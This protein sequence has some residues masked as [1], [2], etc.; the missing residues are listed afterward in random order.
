[1]QTR[2][3]ALLCLGLA[4]THALRSLAQ[5]P[6]RMGAAARPASFAASRRRGLRPPLSR[7][8]RVRMAIDVD[9]RGAVGVD[10]RGE[11]DRGL[12][13]EEFAPCAERGG[14]SSAAICALAAVGGGSTAV[15]VAEFKRAV[16]LCS[17]LLTD[18]LPDDR[19][20]W[21]LPLLGG[22]AVAFLRLGTPPATTFDSSLGR[23][24]EA[25]MAGEPVDLGIASVRTV[26][27]VFTLG[28]GCSLG[29]EGP[30][31]ELGAVVARLSVAIA[32]LSGLGNI[33]SAQRRTLV[34]SGAA[35][36]VAAG[37][38][39]P[40]A[41]IAFAYEVASALRPFSPA[42]SVDRGRGKYPAILPVTLASATAALVARAILA[43]GLSFDPS[44]L[45]EGSASVAELPIYM[46]LGCFCGGGAVVFRYATANSRA[47]FRDTLSPIVSPALQPIVGGGA[48]ALLSLIVPEVQFS[49]YETLDGL[50]S[51]WSLLSSPADPLVLYAAKS[52]ATAVCLGSGLVGG[53]FAP[54]LFLGAALGA[55]FSQTFDGLSSVLGL[56]HATP[57]ELI[58]TGAASLLSAVFSSPFTGALLI[59]DKT[60]SLQLLL[61][62]LL[63]AAI[64]SALA[65]ELAPVDTPRPAQSME[66]VDGES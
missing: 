54:S 23:N 30:A 14:A 13:D 42:T 51:S 36:G 48:C 5:P 66:T 32:G 29:P 16:L 12:F 60:H 63:S 64:A 26:A 62:S 39:A 35:A 55:V 31:V 47:F 46:L 28:T 41:A 50:V 20:L 44:I 59:F 18:Q 17:T 40:L 9:D 58:L 8:A 61:P 45:G 49:S 52:M 3:L 10:D 34:C 11:G 37:F 4:S 53:L 25:A 57:S 27:S 22:C 33:T 7:S 2:I 43:N 6:G 19:F 56:G 15:L 65:D 21:A 24:V 38:N 1:M